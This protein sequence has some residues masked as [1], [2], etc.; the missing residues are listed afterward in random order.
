MNLYSIMITVMLLPILVV[1]GIMVKLKTPVLPEASGDPFGLIEGP[2]EPVHLIV[3]G[4]STVAGLGV[5]TYDQAIASQAASALG[6]KIARS[7]SWR[8]FGRNGMMAYDLRKKYLPKMASLKA[9]II[10]VSLGVNDVL[11]MHGPRR[12]A[13]DLHDLIAELRRL[14]GDIPIVLNG[15]APMGYFPAIPQPLRYVLGLRAR[16]LDRTAARLCRSFLN[17]RHCSTPH[18]EDL[19]RISFAS[20]GFHPNAT[21]YALLGDFLGNCMTECLGSEKI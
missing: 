9:D 11:H 16:V 15:I 10:L 4:E 18:A 6:R 2:G 12:Y 17:V 20:D 1:Q 14:F 5:E 21:G 13:R 3:L 8:S 7:V 19:I